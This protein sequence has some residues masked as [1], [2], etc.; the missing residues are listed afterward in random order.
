[1]R[2]CQFSN[3]FT[4]NSSNF[5]LKLGKFD[6]EVTNWKGIP[7]LWTLVKNCEFFKISLARMYA[8]INGFSGAVK[9]M[10]QIKS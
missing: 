2:L 7:D 10:G 8:I 3:Y 9:P 4:E 5:F 6:R 1:M